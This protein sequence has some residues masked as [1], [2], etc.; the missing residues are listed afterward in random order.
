MYFHVQVNIWMFLAKI[1]KEFPVRLR[2]N[3]DYK[4]QVTGEGKQWEKR[5]PVCH[6]RKKFLMVWE[7]AE[8]M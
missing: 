3:E 1:R 2:Y 5:K 4:N 6:G 8:P 7:T